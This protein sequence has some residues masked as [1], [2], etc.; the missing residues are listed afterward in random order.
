MR[1]VIKADNSCLFNAVAYNL[2]RTRSAASRLRRVVKDTVEADP[3]TFNDGLLGKANNDYQNWI[4]NMDHWGGP[5]ELVILAKYFPCLLPHYLYSP[6]K[7]Y[8]RLCTNVADISR[9]RVLDSLLY[10]FRDECDHVL[11]T[12][13][14]CIH[15]DTIVAKLRHLTS[16]PRGVMCMAR[17]NSTAEDAWSYMMVCIMMLS[18]RPHS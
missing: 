6:P 18:Q 13:T 4:M 10:W 3:V 17:E 11:T 12:V 5:I 15:A 2:E 16:E 1:R 9:N 7:A 14:R 8:A